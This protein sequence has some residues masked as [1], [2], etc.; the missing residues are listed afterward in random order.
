M[1]ESVTLIVSIILLVLLIATFVMTFTNARTVNEIME[2]NEAEYARQEMLER[3]VGVDDKSQVDIAKVLMHCARNKIGTAIVIEG[4]TPL[5]HIE[6][7]G[8]SA[9]IIDINEHILKTLIESPYT[10]KGAILIRKNHIVTYNGQMRIDERRQEEN[11]K[12]INIGLGSRHVGALGE[13]MNN[14]GTVIAVVSQETGKISLF[15]HLSGKLT[16]DVGL[17]LK[18]LNIRGGVTQSQIEYRLNDLLVGQ[19]IEASLE[20]EQVLTDIAR[21]KETPEQRKARRKREK[22]LAKIKKEEEKE[23]RRLEKE[24]E[25]QERELAKSKTRRG[26]FY[27][28]EQEPEPKPEPKPEPNQEERPRRRRRRR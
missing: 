4:K 9:G 12:L 10:N 27:S 21:K 1:I 15:G 3:T 17:E 23:Q 5:E 14:E 20:S 7:S 6:Q 16:A 25:R 2:Y 19:G 18:E 11:R 24:Q 8:D 22:E 28:N 13:V 26:E